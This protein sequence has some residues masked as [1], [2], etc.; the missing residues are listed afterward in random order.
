[1]R[2]A[3]EGIAVV[4]LSGRFPDATDADTLWRNVVAGKESIHRFSDAALMAAGIPRELLDAPNY[5]KARPLLDDVKHFDATCFSMTAR[6]AE[7]TDPQLRLLMECAHE[8]L[9]QAGYVPGDDRTVG[10]YA[11]VRLSRYLEEH[12]IPNADVVRSVGI[13][14]LQMI[15]RKDSAATLLA[16]RLDLTGPAISLN[17]AC[18][19]GLVAVHLGCSALA[20]HECDM[21]LAGAAAIP[22]FDPEGYLHTVGGILSPDGHCR[23]FDRAAQGTIDG[24][25]VG[26]VALMRIE[27]AIERRV[28]VLAVIRGTSVNNDGGVKIGYT[29]P[30]VDGQARVIAEAM[31]T[32]DVSADTIGYVE[33]HGTATPLGDPI[34]IAALTRAY[35]LDTDRIGF[36]GISSLKSNIGHLGAAAGIGGLIK[37]VQAV[38]HGVLP[39]SLHFHEANPELHLDESPFY[40]IREPLPWPD[41]H[42]PRRASVSSFGIGG[43]N[44]HLILE[45]A[46]DIAA[47]E[48]TATPRHAWLLPFSA[49]STAGLFEFARRLGRVWSHE[50]DAPP[51]A[52]ASYTLQQRRMHRRYRGF[53]VAGDANEAAKAFGEIAAFERPP[54]EAPD[55]SPPVLFQFTGQGAQR[56]GMGLAAAAAEPRLAAALDECAQWLRTDHGIDLRRLIADGRDPGSDLTLDDTAGAQPALFALEW[57]LGR[58]WLNAG[59]RPVA[60]VGHSLGELVAATLANVMSLRDALRLVVARG[61][62]MQRAPAGA[63]LAVVLDETALSTLLASGT[64]EVGNCVI[65]AV[66]GPKACVVSGSFAGIAALESLLD[67]EHLTYRRLNTSHAFHSPLMEPVLD[68]YRAAFEGITLRLPDV[69]IFSTVTSRPLDDAQATDPAYWIGQ[70]R[71]PVQYARAL[72]AALATDVATGAVVL[73]LGPGRTLSSAA[74][75]IVGPHHA[76]LSS[77]GGVADEGRA[78]LDTAGRLWTLGIDIDWAAWSDDQDAKMAWLPT[79]PFDRRRAWIDRARPAASTSHAAPL[80]VSTPADPVPSPIQPT[81]EGFPMSHSPSDSGTAMLEDQLSAIW[82]D[83]LGDRP[84]ARNDSF[85]DLGGNSLLALQV[86]G[87]IN[88]T[89]GVSINPADMLTKP[90]IAELADAITD[91]LL[92]KTDAANLDTLLNDMSHL[93]DDEVRELLKQA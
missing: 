20:N 56:I 64:E 18:S 21:V 43:T 85:F 82:R 23:P 44:A 90:T 66:N 67:R 8:A 75:G 45:Q 55:V 79:M 63:M 41:E 65:S 89:F 60:F 83:A 92:G 50:G 39:P 11:G 25:G 71:A 30:S 59:V 27:D 61:A 14:S 77:L 58:V 84:I 80:S 35:R 12:L 73:E 32:A 28:P 88:Q 48:S 70:L 34:E 91:K 26:M 93:S 22:A 15:N 13:D 68:T 86:V 52:D 51:L 33:T 17:T 38:R 3:L 54:Q 24:A 62:A 19:T 74:L 6:E 49:T 87:R 69:P 76:V 37:A 47:D 9:E 5:V 81:D 40:V 10:V 1:M 7:I 53:V 2:D 42:H 36:C 78:L 31:A 46:P 4:G 16:Y 57:A 29:A 72:Q